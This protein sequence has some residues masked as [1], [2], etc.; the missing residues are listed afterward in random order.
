MKKVTLVF[1]VLCLTV[2][3]TIGT[4]S[5]ASLTLNDNYIG[6]G[7]YKDLDRDVVG[8][9]KFNI[10]SL[11]MTWDNDSLAI[12]I[13]TNYNGTNGTNGNNMY[14]TEMGDF[15]I[16][17]NGYSPNGSTPYLEDDFSNGEKWEYAFVFDNH[18]IYGAGKVAGGDFSLYKLTSGNDAY[19]A[20]EIFT[21]T[22]FHSPTNTI[23]HN[24]EVRVDTT[25]TATKVVD[26]ST[27]TADWLTGSWFTDTTGIHLRIADF[28]TWNLDIDAVRWQMT[29]GNDI[30]EG[31]PVPEPA[32]LL[33]LG[34]GLTALVGVSRKKIMKK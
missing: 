13:F 1:L 2:F 14:G 11:D 9:N 4:A 28:S 12:D 26:S 31:T 15:F 6:K 3:F 29:C 7:D 34:F 17:T 20:N 23:R 24:Q 18:D 5:A 33:L 10:F 21:S 32:T 27:A 30:I 8:N 16:S 25:T 22:E 19:Y